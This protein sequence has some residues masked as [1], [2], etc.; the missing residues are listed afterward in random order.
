MRSKWRI[1][2]FVVAVMVIIGLVPSPAIAQPERKDLVIRFSSGSYLDRV[3]PDKDNP[4]YL[5]I[6]NLGN[7]AIT[8]IR[9]IATQIR[10]RRRGSRS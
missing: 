6:E 4:L 3:E 8:N 1:L 5:E 10:P 2:W 7:R 9:N